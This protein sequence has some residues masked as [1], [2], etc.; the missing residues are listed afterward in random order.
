MKY[1]SITLNHRQ[2]DSQWNGIIQFRIRSFKDTPSARKV[3]ATVFWAAEGVILVDMP[4]GQT[5]NSDLYIKTQ[6]ALQKL[7]RRI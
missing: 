7:F 4:C 5:I 2:E 3:M 1:G 6:E